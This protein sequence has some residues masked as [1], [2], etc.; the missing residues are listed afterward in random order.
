MRVDFR[1][2]RSDID[3]TFRDNAATVAEI[4]QWVERFT[5]DTIFTV[6]KVS[7]SGYASPEG[8]VK[9]NNSLAR[10]RMDALRNIIYATPST[11]S[12]VPLSLY[13]RV[14]DSV[15]INGDTLSLDR[16]RYATVEFDY[17]EISETAEQVAEIPADTIDAD[18]IAAVDESVAAPE[19]VV[20]A[21]AP[22]I[23]PVE[24]RRPLYIS[25]KSNML[26]DALLIPS[27]GA[28][29]YLGKM[30][31]VSAEWS[32]AWWS[33]DRRHDYWRYY[34][35]DI[36][37]RRWFGRQAA[38]KP[39]TGH[40]IGLYAQIFTYDFEFGK[41]GQMGNKF[42]YGGGVEYGFSL[43]V[44]RRINIDFTIGVGYI[45]GKYYEY[46]PID[47]H[48]VW[49]ATKRRNWFGPAKA[50]VSFVWLIGYGNTNRTKGGNR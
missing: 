7:V 37:V 30:Y 41:K 2:N 12:Y 25:L 9:L 6:N 24:T 31:S 13:S 26:Y 16:L 34:G 18:T 27:I 39:L 50:E 28:E 38:E 21:I 33:C 42:N 36:E 40:H 45:G 35:G 17:D 49:Q 1:V 4:Q 14:A 23:A 5:T 11:L 48:Y 3:T 46:V 20:T 10:K 47:G 19:P 43:P 15:D 29:A 44:A 32:Y 8:P 22:A